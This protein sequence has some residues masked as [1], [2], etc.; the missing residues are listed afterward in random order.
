MKQKTRVRENKKQKVKRSKTNNSRNS[1]VR[2]LVVAFV[3]PLFAV[4][5][6]G[7]L[8]Y[9]QAEKGLREN[10]EEAAMSTIRTTGQYIDLGFELVE[11]EALNYAYDQ[12]LNDYYMGFYEN[13]SAK[14]SQLVSSTLAGMKSTRNTNTFVHGI[15]IVPGEGIA[16]QTTSNI[17]SG[18]GSGFFA[19]LQAE[20]KAVYGTAPNYAWLESHPI[21]DQKLKVSPEDYILSYYCAS[22]NGNAGIM[23]DVSRDAVLE[24]IEGMNMGQ[25]SAMG[26]ITPL[27]TEIAVGE[28]TEFSLADKAIYQELLSSK[29]TEVCTYLPVAGK[30]YL[31]LATKS[32]LANT[33]VYAAV[34]KA[35][36]VEKAESIKIITIILVILS[37]GIVG[38]MAFMIST[39]M[40]KKMKDIFKTLNRAAEGDLTTSIALK[41][42][43]EFTDIGRSINEMISN[44]QKL[45]KDSKDNVYHVS[46][47][48]E[49]VKS[50]SGIINDRA[51]HIHTSIV[52]ID[53]GLSRQKQNADEC[54]QKMDVLSDEI[55]VVVDEISKIETVADSSHE[56]IKSGITEMTFLLSSS[57]NTTKITDKMIQNISLLAEKTKAI[58][59]FVN[60]I[61]EISSQTNLLSLNASIEAARAGEAGRGFS[62]V[63]E[64]IRKLADESQH[65]AE[66]IR[67]TVQM[68]EAQVAETTENADA[69]QKII[70]EQTRTIS[71][72]SAVF[73]KMG[74]GMAELMGSVDSISRNVEHVDKNRQLTKKEVENITEVIHDTSGA[75]SRMSELADELL[76]NAEKMD[77]I[78][79]QL[80]RNTEN[81]EREMT[82][83]TI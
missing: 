29:E 71:G 76:R 50:A 38:G 30:E 72:M 62:V 42:N 5:L 82:V 20:I 81:L 59:E 21:V 7:V 16:V 48:V 1:I 18:G 3:I 23:V 24:V 66:Q 31:I 33:V 47:T 13:D 14:K 40:Q 79:G 78:S 64:E 28:N 10:F 25:G 83:F 9:H 73:D 45:V 39:G 26:F 2:Q 43:D 36:V 52:E 80:M 37:C 22:T 11:A 74:L 53:D 4:V 8:S 35:V 70:G 65:A 60:M 58:E 63:A 75:T 49:E 46:Q 55:K 34:P 69:A 12:S 19:D 77:E 17:L 61:N 6:I 15:H 56:L 41:G 44:M 32:R 54:Q 27:G 57:E 51:E 68:I 67:Q